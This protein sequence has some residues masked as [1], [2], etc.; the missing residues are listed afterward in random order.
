M[1][2]MPA[3]NGAHSP[4]EALIPVYSD[5]DWV[6]PPAPA[7]ELPPAPAVE[8]ELPPPAAPPADAGEPVAF[9]DEDQMPPPP[10]PE[11]AFD[12]LHTLVRLLVGGTVVGADELL[13]RLQAW[14]EA[15]PPAPAGGGSEQ[16]LAQARAR[17]ALVGLIFATYS[18]T[19][20]GVTTAV[21]L[22]QTAGKAAS[23]VLRPVAGSR[24]LRPARRRYRRLAARGQ[25]ELARLTR[26]GQTE[27]VRGRALAR[28]L[29]NTS[30]NDLINFLSDNPE[31]AS[32]IR[33]QVDRML[34]E[35]PEDPKL[36]TLVSTQVEVM[37]DELPQNERLLALV[38]IQGDQ[39]LAYL[40]E[41]PDAVQELVQGQSI[42]L[43]GE[44][45][46]EVRER[47][48]TADSLAE[49]IV[50]TLLKRTPRSEIPEPPLAVQQ[51]ALTARLRS[52]KPYPATNDEHPE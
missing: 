50:R 30:V 5:E 7:G 9:I 24:L 25:A 11:P 42:G 36:Q 18:T 1:P 40:Q 44:M 29:F 10:P 51:Q 15:Q 8:A 21:H 23:M 46:D 33:V 48:V 2:I 31:I 14:E 19:R 20:K 4:E 35:L 28:D 17:Y 22:S 13:R 49:R 26:Q 39:Y 45:L 52:A 43:A 37:L 47:T 27:E 12:P 32:L 38:R 16:E 34:D 6:L 3:E 41:N